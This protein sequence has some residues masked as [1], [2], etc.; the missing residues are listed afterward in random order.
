M[1][2]HPAV[3][4]AT[5][6]AADEAAAEMRTRAEVFARFLFELADEERDLAN[7]LNT[8]GTA[9]F[10]VGYHKGWADAL[11]F[12]ARSLRQRFDLT[13]PVPR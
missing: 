2:T 9:Y 8:A 12:A 6:L 10:P 13:G 11:N 4:E 1:T 7:A 3:T 5:S